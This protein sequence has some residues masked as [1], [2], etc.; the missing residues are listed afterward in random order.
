MGRKHQ[1]DIDDNL[2]LPCLLFD[3]LVIEDSY[4]IIEFLCRKSSRVDLLGN[5]P[6]EKAIVREIF[7]SF[8][9]KG[10]MEIKAYYEFALKCKAL[11]QKK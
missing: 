5:G 10:C 8:L 3:G 7:Y 6:E 9:L 1:V 4:A 11:P 2:E